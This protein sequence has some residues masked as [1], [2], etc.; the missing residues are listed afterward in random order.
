MFD[1]QAFLE[2][3][4][5]ESDLRGG[6]VVLGVGEYVLTILEGTHDVDV[7]RCLGKPLEERGQSLAPLVSLGVVLD[8]LVGVDDRH[9]RRVTG[10]D[11][12]QEVPNLLFPCRGAHGDSP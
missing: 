7:G 11:A 4:D 3:E 9:R 8:V 6:E 2:S 10:F 5:F 12:F 1:H